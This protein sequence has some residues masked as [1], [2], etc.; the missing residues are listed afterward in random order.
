[1]VIF[2][3]VGA[4]LEATQECAGAEQGRSRGIGVAVGTIGAS[5]PYHA[6]RSECAIS[7]HATL[8]DLPVP[9]IA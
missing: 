8:G 6:A 4:V 1:M 5:G 7:A 2:F 3:W 9:G